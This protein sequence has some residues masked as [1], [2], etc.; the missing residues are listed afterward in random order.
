[1]DPNKPESSSSTR[2]WLIGCGIGCG[3]IIVIAILVGLGGY[4]FIRNIVQGF[5]DS[6]AIMS[7]LTERYG[8][9]EEYCPEPDGIIFPDRMEAFLAAR[10]AIRLDREELEKSVQILDRAE[11]EKEVE[12]DSSGSVFKKVRIGFG[13][14]PQIADFFKARNQ[15]LLDVGMGIGEYYYLYL[16]VYFSWLKKSVV[17]GPSFRMIGDEDYRNWD[18]EQSRE[19]RLDMTLRRLHRMLLPMLENQYGKLQEDP[20]AQKIWTQVLAG[21][22]E[23]M[24]ADRY[25]M[26][27]QDGLPDVISSSLEPFRQ[28]LEE[29]YSPLL[30][31]LEIVLEQR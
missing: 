10:E 26:I 20:G 16:V 17:D 22:I 25:R 6:E 15:A 8:R 27:W 19:I 2:K 4:L 28:R 24:H 7:A 14:V 11:F 21:E 18:D 5:E 9:V 23:A 29:S 13:L 3:V 30:N 12:R 31:T 1:M